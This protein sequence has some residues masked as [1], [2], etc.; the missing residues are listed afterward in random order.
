MLNH[1]PSP[2]ETHRLIYIPIPPAW[3]G[4]DLPSDR[5]EAISSGPGYIKSSAQISTLESLSAERPSPVCTGMQ[6]ASFR[7]PWR[8]AVVSKKTTLMKV[9]QDI[10]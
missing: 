9:H 3:V 4:V 10:G 8:S 7:G 5:Q 2:G 6:T 1:I